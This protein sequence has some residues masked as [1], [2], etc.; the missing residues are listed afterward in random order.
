MPS[1]GT[2]HASNTFALLSQ[3]ERS[4]GKSSVQMNGMRS[5]KNKNLQP[6]AASTE[7][8]P[9]TKHLVDR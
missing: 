6:A 7:R 1:E 8:L 5:G 3:P 9:V 2:K 4:S